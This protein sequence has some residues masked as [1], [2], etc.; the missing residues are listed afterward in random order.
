MHDIVLPSP[1]VIIFITLLAAGTGSCDPQQQK[2][3]PDAFAQT[4]GAPIPGAELTLVRTKG[5]P[6]S[7]SFTLPAL[8]SLCISVESDASSATVSLDAQS[9]LGPSDFKN[10]PLDWT[11]E[12]NDLSSDLHTVALSI[13]GKPGSEITV[14]AHYLVQGPADGVTLST[15]DEAIIVGQAY[16]QAHADN[17]LFAG[18]EN[19]QATRATALRTRDG[20]LEGFEIDVESLEGV[21][22]GYLVLEAS[23][24]RPLLGAAATEGLSLTETL[25]EHYEATS[26]A[27]LSE[28]DDH[29]FLW[30]GVG[31]M[32]LEVT[33]NNQLFIEETCETCGSPYL[34]SKRPEV[35]LW[36]I[37]LSAN[38]WIT[39]RQETLAEM[40]AI[41]PAVK[42][43]SAVVNVLGGDRG[44]LSAPLHVQPF[45]CIDEDDEYCNLEEKEGEL[46]TMIPK[47]ANA[48]SYF[49]QEKR[50]WEVPGDFFWPNCHVGCTPLA[51]VT[52]LDYWDRLGYEYLIPDMH[53][54][55]NT[56][57]EDEDVR[58]ALQSLRIELKT[59]CEEGSGGTYPENVDPGIKSYINLAAGSH[60]NG[61]GSIEVGWSVET[62]LC[63]SPNYALHAFTHEIQL[64]R[65]ALMHYYSDRGENWL[66]PDQQKM[67]LDYD[68]PA[69][70]S[71]VVYGV[72][73][74][75]DDSRFDD[76]LAVRTGWKIGITK[77]GK[78]IPQYRLEATVGTGRTYITSIKPGCTAGNE[79]ELCKTFSDL[80]ENHW[81]HDSVE[82]L[83]C[84]CVVQGHADGSFGISDNVTKAE[85]LKMIIRLAYS[86]DKTDDLDH[87]DHGVHWASKYLEFAKTR[88]LLDQLDKGGE[89]DP[90]APITRQEAAFVVVKAGETANV[91]NY[92]KGK[93]KCLPY[94]CVPEM[95]PYPYEDAVVDDYCPY[96]LI[97]TDLCI[98][99]GYVDGEIKPE[100]NI[101]R[102]EAAKV[103]CVARFGYDADE[104]QQSANPPPC[105]SL[106]EQCP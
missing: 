22:A 98:F 76:A 4:C 65:P 13:A 54:L 74:D 102:V 92:L 27:S 60:A 95:S 69:N 55:N 47:G 105:V 30:G 50:E 16:I 41:L 25:V 66:P 83:S 28:A 49:Y 20:V 96:V 10:K 71:A 85:F 81:G 68:I 58:D 101:S 86:A 21:D 56:S 67:C 18:W 72:Y 87:D 70:H 73:D 103:A 59:T 7:A 77:S 32:A 40:L 80:P 39:L 75:G 35:E 42:N 90:D 33:A 34:S 45:T 19:A 84:M 31:M 104:C 1:R 38:E 48:F 9:V 97:A 2:N 63:S 29:V 61:G 36:Q 53:G 106:P 91:P 43:N 15:N 79:V 93:S 62:E 17:A 89:F 44:D 14:R 57:V 11:F 8:Q 99:E 82:T 24:L 51:A 37:G 3:E 64:Q 52:L 26:G 88:G 23:A 12:Y 5:K 46:T 100:N 94:A 6:N 78:K